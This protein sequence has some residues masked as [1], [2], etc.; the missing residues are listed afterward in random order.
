MET[1]L[2]R[3]FRWLSATPSSRAVSTRATLFWSLPWAQG[4]PLAGFSSAGPSDPA[5]YGSACP[6][7]RA[8]FPASVFFANGLRE[9][10]SN[11][12]GAQGRVTSE[13]ALHPAVE[14]DSGIS[15]TGGALGLAPCRQGRNKRPRQLADGAHQVIVGIDQAKAPD[16]FLERR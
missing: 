4:S 13:V 2:Q 6:G 10:N 12:A 9:G 15:R 1:P 16:P 11:S 8:P 7:V 3:R 5:P 14:K